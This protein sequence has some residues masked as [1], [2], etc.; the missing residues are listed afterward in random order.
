[1]NSEQRCVFSR[2]WRIHDASNGSW[3]RLLAHTCN[4]KYLHPIKQ[5]WRRGSG[6]VCAGFVPGVLIL[7]QA[8][9]KQGLQHST[10]QGIFPGLHWD[11]TEQR[12]HD[13]CHATSLK[14]NKTSH[15]FCFIVWMCRRQSVRGPHFS[16][17]V[18]ERWTNLV[19]TI[20]QSE[21]SP[22]HAY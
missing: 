12:G 17:K 3:G 7:S 20:Q 21:E 22:S 16:E 15:P 18:K 14:A 8:M 4:N 6:Q 13:L 5:A 19:P 9:L 2:Q 11:R 1:M 10:D